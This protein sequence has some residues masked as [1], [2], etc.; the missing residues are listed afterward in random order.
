MLKTRTYNLSGLRVLCFLAFLLLL[1][2]L[3]AE[4]SGCYNDYQ[5]PTPVCDAHTVV[6]LANDGKATVYAS[7]FDDG[8]HDNCQISH[9]KAAR[10]NEGWCPY[11]VVDDTQFR[12]YVQFCCEDIGWPIWI[13]VRVFDA[14]GN[15]N[16]CMVEVTVQDKLDPWI[17]CPPDITVSCEFWFSENALW[18]PWDRTFGTVV[19]N[20]Y[21]R[22]SIIINDPGNNY[23]YQPHNWGLDG[24]AKDNCDVWIDIVNVINI[25]GTCGNRVIKRIWRATDS[26]GRTK[27]C[28]QKITVKDYHPFHGYNIHWPW[29]YEAD[30]CEVYYYSPEYLPHGYNKPTFDYAGNC[31]LIGIN[32]EDQVFTFVEGACKKILR[33][34]SVIDWCQ[35]D[36]HHPWYGGLWT[37][38][39][40]I[41]LANKHKP[42]I[43]NCHDITV[44]GSE[45]YCKGE[46][47]LDPGVY[48]DCTPNDKLNFEYKIDI[49]HN[50]SIDIIRHDHP[51][52]HETLPIGTHKVLWF[53]D[54]GCGNLST[55]SFK[56]TIV[57]KKK[58]TPVCYYGLSS[59]VMP[60]SGMI[61]IWARDFNAS[62]FD[63]C[64]PAH[65]LKYSFSSN[66]WEASKTFTC[67]DIDTNVVQIW[68]T[69]EWGNQDY[70]TTFI[71]IDDNENVCEEM[72]PLTGLVSSMAGNPVEGTEV[73]LYKIMPSGEHEMDRMKESNVEGTFTTGFGTTQYDRYL[74]AQK[75]DDLMD[76]VSA[77]DLII[78]QNHV[79]GVQPFESSDQFIA[80]DLDHS[81]HIGV[82]DMSLLRD[83][84]IGLPAT[85]ENLPWLFVRKDCQ[86]P[87]LND[88][89]NMS[90]VS[91]YTIDHLNIPDETFDF[92]AIK[93]GDINGDMESGGIAGR[94]SETVPV[95]ARWKQAKDDGMLLEF[96]LN[97]DLSYRG[98]QMSVAL[99]QKD[100]I[101]Q[102]GIV[103]LSPSL[104]RYDDG[105]QYL[106]LVHAQKESSDLNKGD[107]LYTLYFPAAGAQLMTRELDIYKGRLAPEIY[108]GDLR[109]LAITTE[110]QQTQVAAIMPRSAVN[111]EVNTLSAILSPNPFRSSAT[112]EI[113]VGK[114]GEG[115]LL[116]SDISGKVLTMRSISLTSGVNHVALEAADIGSPGVYLYHVQVDG[117]IDSGKLIVIQ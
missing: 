43:T 75:Q 15:Y 8:S 108:T 45:P 72:N 57:D 91:G 20:Q 53:I 59:V 73:M 69:D 25:E 96:V 23:Y 112:L 14:A 87:P 100:F 2:P 74:T 47:W 30:D 7:T 71:I 55:C 12:P 32:Y 36:P 21:E 76:G 105:M 115:E 78:L 51:V 114:T 92:L 80:G 46:V 56:V 113:V 24:Y 86:M 31:S 90:C 33:T 63:N 85:T 66:V 42:H 54:D 110:W 81:E 5:P 60:S 19:K 34:W 101:V 64:T 48:D 9:F 58:P 26:G 94:S 83:I 116:I 67:D 70:C 4:E 84:L 107:I 28:T 52:V 111:D 6:S 98:M 93:V 117:A 65:K 103:E 1:T 77:L 38:V 95:I 88:P 68:V 22:Q 40:V 37:H 49:H 18:D 89:F 102:S 99:P 44:G 61:T 16:D 41:K 62:S 11:G 17:F 82:K 50:G 10:M 39:Q 3:K 79:I 35:Y 27:T 97:T 13:I 29:D 104:Y 106:N 109:A